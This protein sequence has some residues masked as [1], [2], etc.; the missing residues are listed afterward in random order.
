VVSVYS[1]E[2]RD[3]SLPSVSGNFSAG[4]L[5]FREPRAH[6]FENHWSLVSHSWSHPIR[7]VIICRGW[8][9]VMPCLREPPWKPPV[10]I[11]T[12]VSAGFATGCLGCLRTTTRV[13][14]RIE[15]QLV[16]LIENRSGQIESRTSGQSIKCIKISEKFPNRLFGIDLRTKV[17]GGAAGTNFNVHT[18]NWEPLWELRIIRHS[19]IAARAA[20][21]GGGP[22]GGPRGVG[23]AGHGLPILVI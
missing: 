15:Y 13:S 5:D 16:V 23:G 17:G 12:S 22:G 1:G 14:L 11:F 2:L 18:F 10:I 6:L 8:R 3:I 9:T 20:A 21:G 19:R 7:P 4:Y